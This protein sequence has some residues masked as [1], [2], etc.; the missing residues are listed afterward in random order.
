MKKWKKLN[1]AVKDLWAGTLLFFLV[2]TLL[3]LFVVEQKGQFTLGL[4]VG[5]IT[6]AYLVYHMYESI[7]AGLSLEEEAAAR[8]LRNKSIQRWLIRLVVV[9]ASVYIPYVSVV[10]VMVGMFGLKFSAYFQ[11]GIH[12]LVL[13]LD[14]NM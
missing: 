1:S 14:K 9:F 12:K 10:G 5:S 11:P 13:K 3:G 7:D 4:L 8:Y 6:T 2:F